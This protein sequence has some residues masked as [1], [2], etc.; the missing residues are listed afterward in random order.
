MS[1][2]PAPGEVLVLSLALLRGG[3][4]VATWPSFYPGA[5]SPI[6]TAV[7]RLSGADGLTDLPAA[8]VTLV[9]HLPG[10]DAPAE[11]VTAVNAW[12]AGAAG[13]EVPAE[14][15]IRAVRATLHGDRGVLCAPADQMPNLLSAI[16]RYLEVLTRTIA[17]R[18][19]LDAMWPELEAD[20]HLLH[21]VG[22]DEIARLPD[23]A[24]RTRLAAGMRLRLV[25]ASGFLDDPA[26]FPDPLA[27]R[28][29]LELAQQA[30]LASRLAVLDDMI[31][32]AEDM[33]ELANDRLLEFRMFDR[34]SRIELA[35]LIAIVGE[36][37]LIAYDVFF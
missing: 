13:P 6:A 17:D 1:R 31:E 9:L 30:S 36:L 26:A 14:V 16:V 25:R 12:V 2:L 15:Q 33:S 22:R 11:L 34:E 28:V 8:D 4:G 24:R 35:I 7:S 29:V 21:D 20:A 19:A 37:L 3:S 10:S 32:V 18:A 5:P 23:V 27:R